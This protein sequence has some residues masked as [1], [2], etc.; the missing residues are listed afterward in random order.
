MIPGRINCHAW[1]LPFQ[2]PCAVGMSI[3][4]Y[5]AIYV[6][7]SLVYSMVRQ[8]LGAEGRFTIVLARLLHDKKDVVAQQIPVQRQAESEPCASS[9]AFL[10]SE[11]ASS[12][13]NG[14]L[15]R[16]MQQD[17]SWVKVFATAVVKRRIK[18][19]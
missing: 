8:N 3:R 15:L 11:G 16:M 1:Q 5:R 14:E 6:F 4:N 12:A 10:A 17:M 7:R 18:A 13:T 2:Q 9:Y 19:S